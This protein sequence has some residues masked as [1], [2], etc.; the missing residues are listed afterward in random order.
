[1]FYSSTWSGPGW[2]PTQSLLSVLVSIQSL[3]NDKPYHNEP[4]YHQVSYNRA[5]SII[6]TL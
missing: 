2:T 3:L 1:M 6:T 5:T 4:G